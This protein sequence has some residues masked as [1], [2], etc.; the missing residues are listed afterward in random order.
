MA[1]IQKRIEKKNDLTILTVHGKVAAEQIIEALV[2]F[3]EGAL[4]SKLLWDYT[5]A[6]LTGV[7]NDELRQISSVAVSYAHLRKDG[8][9]AIVMPATLGF[10]LGRMYEIICENDESPINYNIFKDAREAREWLNS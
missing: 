3:Y 4:T 1:Q 5:D 8:H 9:T 6:D 2:D 7:K 10:G